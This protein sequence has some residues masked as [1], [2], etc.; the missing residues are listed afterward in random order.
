MLYVECCML[1][2]V[3]C[4][5]ITHII[6]HVMCLQMNEDFAAWMDGVARTEEAKL[7]SETD[8][9]TDTDIASTSTPST[10][11]SAGLAAAEAHKRKLLQY[12]RQ[13]QA[14][15]AVIDDQGDYFVS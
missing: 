12:A 6:F 14:R 10:D 2:V 11:E 8:T 4:V 1:Y 15:T 9:K 5:V 13:Q 3:C 7:K